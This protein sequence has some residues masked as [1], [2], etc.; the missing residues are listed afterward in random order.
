MSP[1]EQRQRM[2]KM[3]ETVTKY[4]VKYWADRLLDQFKHL[5]RKTINSNSK[6]SNKEPATV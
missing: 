5:K 6:E 1:E 2:S 3:Y 4:D